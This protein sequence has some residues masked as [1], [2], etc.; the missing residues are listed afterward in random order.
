MR[1]FAKDDGICQPAIEEFEALLSGGDIFA[2]VGER[3]AEVTIVGDADLAGVATIAE[4]FNGESVCEQQVVS[5]NVRL[6]I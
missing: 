6:G 3:F 1:I 5:D 4:F 2:L